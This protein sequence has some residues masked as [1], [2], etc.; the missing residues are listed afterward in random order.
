MVLYRE[1]Y[2][3]IKITFSKNVKYEN[4]YKFITQHTIDKKHEKKSMLTPFE[5][6]DLIV[7]RFIGFEIIEQRENYCIL[8]SMVDVTEKEFDSSLKRVFLL[9]QQMGEELVEAINKNNIDSLEHVHDIDINVDKFHDYCIRVLNK[10]GFQS[11]QK[12]YLIF[13]SLFI[14]ELLGDEFKNITNHILNEKKQIRLENL[15][16]L[17]HMVVAHLNDYCSLYHEFDKNKVMVMAKKDIDIHLFLPKFYQKK[18]NRSKLND[19]ELEI[20]NHLRRITR[21][22]NTLIELRMEMEY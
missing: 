7:H 19:S 8:K 20:F 13:S 15:K 10:T 5:F 3:E 12:T 11:V 16:G 21:Y 6:L 17:S 22:I 2:D 18:N 4:P 9:V 14:M 1:G